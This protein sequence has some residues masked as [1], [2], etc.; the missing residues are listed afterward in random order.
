[1]KVIYQK[2]RSGKTTKLIQ[3][4][5]DNWIYIVTVDEKRANNI[6]HMAYELK[7]DIPYPITLQEYLNTKMRGSHIKKVLIDDADDILKNIFNTVEIDT[8]TMSKIEK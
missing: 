2:P 5:H 6:A 7:I 3:M 4:S 1:M 8:I